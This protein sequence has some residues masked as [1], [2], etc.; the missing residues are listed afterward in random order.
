MYYITLHNS[1]Q[2]YFEEKIKMKTNTNTK[3]F[4]AHMLRQR[5]PLVCLITEGTGKIWSETY[6]DT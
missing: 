2:K 3:P 1:D 6:F 4:T 5:L